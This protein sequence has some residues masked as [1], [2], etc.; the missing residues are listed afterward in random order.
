MTT[1]SLSATHLN[2]IRTL[3]C[4]SASLPREIQYQV[5]PIV[6]LARPML[7]RVRILVAD[8]V[9]IFGFS[10]IIIITF[11]LKSS[12]FSIFIHLYILIGSSYF[13]EPRLIGPASLLSGREIPSERLIR[14]SLLSLPSHITVPCKLG[15]YN[16]TI[17]LFCISISPLIS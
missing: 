7:S 15:L 1:I 16:S 8:R 6:Q 10:P 17:I 5:V 12:I 9:R 14:Y 4:R 3:Q 13:I 2:S 11:P